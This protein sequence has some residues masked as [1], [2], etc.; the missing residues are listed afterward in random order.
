[1]AR[2]R[3]YK[4][5][6]KKGQCKKYKGTNKC[7]PLTQAQM[8]FG[9][10]AKAA[11]VVCHRE[12]TTTGAYASCMRKQMKSG[13]SKKSKAKKSTAA[14]SCEGLRKTTTTKGRKGSLKKGYT[15]KNAKGKCPRK[16]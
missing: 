12:T 10:K 14:K 5:G 3:R 6:P 9:T 7:I 1:M 8:Q 16:I 4:S 15:W 11:N 2:V 13:L